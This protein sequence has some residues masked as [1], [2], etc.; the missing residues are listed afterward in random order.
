MKELI[1]LRHEIHQRPEVSNNE[2]AT[3]ERI[4]AF[5]QKY[6]PDEVIKL[7]KT[8][9]IFIFNSEKPGKTTLFRAELD[10]LPITEINNLD[11]AS[12]NEGV[13][14]S[15]GHDGHM[16][17]L[18]GL[19]KKISQ[20]RPHMGRAVLLFQ[21]AEEVEQGARDVIE[22]PDFIKLKPNYVFALHNVPGVEKSKILI[23]QGSF[24]AASK[25]MTIKLF[26][27][28]SHA[29]EPEKGINPVIAI[30]KI[31]KRFNDLNQEQ[32]SDLTFLTIIHVLMG[33]ISF[34]TSPG[35]AEIRA[36]LR[37]FE[38]KDMKL[39]TERAEQIVNQVA[40]EEKLKEEISF[41][42]VFPAVVNNEECVKIIEKAVEEADL[43][44]ERMKQPFRW[45][46]DFGYF[47]NEYKGGFFGL[48]SGINQ[49]ALHNPDYDFP[50][51]IIESGVEV[52]FNIYKKLNL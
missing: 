42:E 36:T 9:L 27:K 16:T 7:G 46:E 6:S 43:K 26:G 15:C 1:K 10:A 34:G 48:G 19:A 33:K 29:A 37:A 44:I 52:F 13:A 22:H 4:L 24:A 18:A 2:F 45:S 8:G 31:I 32:F 51:D 47:S 14:H 5:V 30:S 17:I 35:Y 28:T 49:P 41:S 25:G 20:N 40:K 50:D 39:L 23:K 21:P 38:N 3:S 11:Y 12:A